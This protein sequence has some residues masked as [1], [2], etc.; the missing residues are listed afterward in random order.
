MNMSNDKKEARIIDL[1]RISL[2]FAGAPGQVEHL[3]RLVAN[4]EQEREVN[5][6]A[7]AELRRANAELTLAMST[8]QIDAV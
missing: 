4:L 2:D 8:C 7:I 1:K 5:L 3:C 6:A